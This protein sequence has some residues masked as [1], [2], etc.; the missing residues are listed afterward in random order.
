MTKTENTG[1]E[2]ISDA[3]VGRCLFCGETTL[4]APHETEIVCKQC[5]RDNGLRPDG[6]RE[7]P[8]ECQ[9][10]GCR[11]QNTTR[12]AYNWDHE[13]IEIFVCGPCL[14]AFNRG[15]TGNANEVVTG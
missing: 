2:R 12:L 5:E 6:G 8:K 3:Q 14:N 9:I 1:R 15:L 10:E 7:L 13:R 4:A 11:R